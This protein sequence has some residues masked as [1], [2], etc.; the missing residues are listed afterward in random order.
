M[1][2]TCL[3]T[4]SRKPA[5]L[6]RLSTCHR[7]LAMAVQRPAAVGSTVNSTRIGLPKKRRPEKAYSVGPPLVIAY[8]CSRGSL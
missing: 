8:S 4:N 5:V 1:D 2:L 3:S 7:V 6:T